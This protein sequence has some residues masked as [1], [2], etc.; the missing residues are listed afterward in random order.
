MHIRLL[1]LWEEA[2]SSY[3]FVPGL[4]GMGAILL[5]V[6]TV[7]LDGYYR[8]SFQDISDKALV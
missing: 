2:R 3:W 1:K 4:M 6:I 7:S 5:S 8:A